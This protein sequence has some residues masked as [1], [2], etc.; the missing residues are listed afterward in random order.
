MED[1]IE[2]ADL[3]ILRKD[4]GTHEKNKKDGATPEESK[5]KGTLKRKQSVFAGRII[6]VR[7]KKGF[8][9]AAIPTVPV[10]VAWICLFLNV[11]LP[12]FGKYRFHIKK[13]L[14]STSA[15][16]RDG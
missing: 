5:F 8:L 14:V 9:Q 11:F 4:E 2:N 7:E 10:W 6:E 3:E 12:G 16:W 15:S 13:S 1:E